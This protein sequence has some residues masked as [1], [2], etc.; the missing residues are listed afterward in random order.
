M[1]AFRKSHPTLGR[2]RFWRN[3]VRWH[4]VGAQADTSHDSH[5]LAYYLRGASEIDDGLYVMYGPA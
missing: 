5:T 1:I 4:G 2:S 3:H